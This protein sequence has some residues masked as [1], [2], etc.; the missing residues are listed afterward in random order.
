[1]PYV[2]L[3]EASIED[4]QAA[5]SAGSVT[6]VDLTVRYLRR[7]VSYDCDGIE[8]NA[9]PVLNQALFDEAANSDDRRAAGQPVRALE[10]IPYT[11][12][13]SYKVINQV[14]AAGAPAFSALTANEDAYLVKAVRDA[15]GVLLGRSNMPPAACGGMQRGI[16]GRAENPYNLKYLAAAFA[17]GSSNGSAVSTAA[18][19]AS[20]GLGS[21]TVSSGRSP[22]SNNGLI[23]YTPSKGWL[24]C[25]GLW[26]LYPTCDVPVP[27]TRTMKDMVTILDV[28]RVPDPVGEGDF[29]RTQRI[30][31]LPTPWAGVPESLQD[32]LT[33]TS[34]KGLRIAV[35]EIYIGGP[36]PSGAKPVACDPDVIE[37]WQSARADLEAL[38]AEIIIVPDLPAVTAYENPNMV[39]EGCPRLPDNWNMAERG[40]LIAH[41]WNDFIKSFKSA[42]IPDIFAMDTMDIYPDSMRT[43]PE[44]KHFEH[45]NAIHYPHLKEYAKENDLYSV[46]GLNAAVK[47][48][49]GMRKVLH[50]DWLSSLNCD[51]VV[52]PAAGDVGPANADTDFDGAAL[53]WRNGVHYSTGNRAIRHLGI[54]TVSVPMGL[55]NNKQVPMNLTFAGKAYEDVNLLRWAN[56]FE[57]K[58]K[59]RIPPPETP[60]LGTDTFLPLYPQGGALKAPPR[61]QLSIN[62]FEVSPGPEEMLEVI[63]QGTVTS[64]VE[65]ADPVLEIMVDTLWVPDISISK[66]TGSS[67]SFKAVARASKQT[68]RPE[69]NRTRAPVARDQTVCMVVARAVPTGRPSGWLGVK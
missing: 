31:D 14:T 18:S 3:V 9:I 59:H 29:W 4:L 21:E 47:S 46:P 19:F 6:S 43:D 16:Y 27:H 68:E 52:F 69:W 55:L 38:G 49:E 42:E 57:T 40:R 36:T 23:A 15:G 5:L 63:L 37:L 12:K 50:E 60:A 17:S 2:N 28:L 13:D 10:G 24:S 56:A 26:P 34:L 39:P 33:S 67:Y 51:L 32:V 1:M 54:P 66:T 41:A 64:D 44:R 30:V 20:F 58:T 7:I 25:R 61:P 35:P 11:A 48:L 62:Q 53:A 65:N 8:L 45:A 22:A